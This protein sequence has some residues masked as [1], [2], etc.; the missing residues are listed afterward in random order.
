MTGELFTESVRHPRG[1]RLKMRAVV[2]SASLS[3]LGAVASARR[4]RRQIKFLMGHYVFDD[5]RRAFERHIGQLQ[6]LGEFVSTADGLLMLRGEVPIDGSYFHLSFDDGLACLARNAAPVLHE[7]QIP[8]LVF[9]NSAV[10]GAH[11]A[12]ER[13]A[14]EKATN[15][16]QPLKVMDWKQL[17]ESG[18]E[19]GAHTRTHVRLSVVSTDETLLHHEI[20]GCKAEIEAALGRPCRYFAWPYGRETDVDGIALDV[21][22]AAGFEAAF[23]AFR[24]PVIPGR[25]DAFMI[26]RHHFEPHWP[27]GHVRY[28]ALGSRG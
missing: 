27:R 2:R 9:I 22:R 8:A 19:V 23:G 28:F 12:A 26:P 18:F 4:H 17:A 21:I 1:V 20:A 6:A 3:M 11:D 16:A 13:A 10:T 15:Y 24:A 14:W 7:A 5:Q 25:T